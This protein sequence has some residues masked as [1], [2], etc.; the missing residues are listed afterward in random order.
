MINLI[1]VDEIV[2][3][4]L[5]VSPTTSTIVDDKAEKETRYPNLPPA[6]PW[7]RDGYVE[8]VRSSAAKNAFAHPVQYA[9]GRKD[10]DIR[11]TGAKDLDRIRNWESLSESTFSHE[12]W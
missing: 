2:F 12:P 9:G 6:D 5:L 7:P 11:F 8:G 4:L 3:N 1:V 10:S